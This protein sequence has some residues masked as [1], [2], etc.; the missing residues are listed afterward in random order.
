M[1]VCVTERETERERE[2]VISI[3]A[4]VFLFQ[5]AQFTGVLKTSSVERRRDEK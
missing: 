3:D 4:F 1:C 5:E 2:C